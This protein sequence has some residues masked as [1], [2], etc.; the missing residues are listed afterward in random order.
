[1]VGHSL[2]YKKCHAHSFQG[3]QNFV[4]HTKDAVDD[5]EDR[6]TRAQAALDDVE[7]TLREAEQKV[8]SEDA[9]QAAL[10]K[11][12][13]GLNASRA[14]L[15]T[16]SSE[17]KKMQDSQKT[18]PPFMNK[19]VEHANQALSASQQKLDNLQ[20]AVEQKIG[21]L[22]DFAKQADDLQSQLHGVKSR[23]KQIQDKGLCQ[24]DERSADSDEVEVS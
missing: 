11:V 15:E 19:E 4:S 2:K 18:V 8:N 17:V 20:D 6:K 21:I 22:A 13:D 9:D 12:L 24:A 3:T 5:F 23:N 10:E 7:S 14:N 16:A 1:M